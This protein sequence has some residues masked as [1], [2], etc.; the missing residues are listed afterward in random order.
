MGS[1]LTFLFLLKAVD[2]LEAPKEGFFHLGDGMSDEVAAEE[3]VQTEK[4]T[5]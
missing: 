1:F 3:G 2:W 5:L 4:R